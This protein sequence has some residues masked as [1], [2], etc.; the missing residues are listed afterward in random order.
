MLM[1]KCWIGSWKDGSEWKEK[2]KELKKMLAKKDESK[3]NKDQI[4]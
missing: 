1:S 3:K 4:N 2:R